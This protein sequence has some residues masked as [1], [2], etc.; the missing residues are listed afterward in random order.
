MQAGWGLK[1]SGMAEP[2]L[3]SSTSSAMVLP[4]EHISS[5]LGVHSRSWGRESF[6]FSMGGILTS[7]KEQDVT[8][9]CTQNL[10]SFSPPLPPPLFLLGTGSPAEPY[11]WGGGYYFSSF[12]LTA[13]KLP[14][15]MGSRWTSYD[16]GDLSRPY[17]SQQ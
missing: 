13:A 12:P 11:N 16:L 9:R 2:P 14:A 10:R 17:Q 8:S 7:S 15:L 6:F 5:W 4:C 1:F 3:S